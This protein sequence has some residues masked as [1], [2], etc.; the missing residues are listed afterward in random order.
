ME[1]FDPAALRRAVSD[2]QEFV[3]VA[4]GGDSCAEVARVGRFGRFDEPRDSA[5]LEKLGDDCRVG[6]A[7][8]LVLGR[9]IAALDQ[10]SLDQAVD[11]RQGLGRRVDDQGLEPLPLG[12]PVMPIKAG[13][14]HDKEMRIADPFETLV[15]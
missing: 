2:E 6:C 9:R 7:G 10:H 3:Q 1:P 14:A 4:V 13:F 15:A 8:C 5:C 11:F 12:F